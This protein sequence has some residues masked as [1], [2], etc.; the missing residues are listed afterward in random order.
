MELPRSKFAI[1]AIASPLEK[2][3]LE[4]WIAYHKKIG[5]D[6]FFI[7][8]NDWEWECNDSSVVLAKIDGRQ[9][10]CYYYTW[11]ARNMSSYVDWC[12]FI[13]CD[14]FIRLGTKHRTVHDLADENKFKDAICLSWRLF[15]SNGMHF[16]G[17]YNVLSRFTRRQSGFN[18]HIKTVLNLKK[19]ASFGDNRSITFTTPH[20]ATCRSCTGIISYSV[21]NRRIIG[22]YDNYASTELHDNDTWLAHFFCKTPEEWRLKQE[23]GR[24]DVAEDSPLMH[25]PDE[26]FVNHDLNDVEDTSLRDVLC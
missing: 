18:Q 15:G 25:R 20:C 7:A 3:Y 22:P 26:D 13:D 4:E 10:Q 2:N 5:V 8:T 21:D 19:L 14:E 17:D 9:K 1:C 23:R 6:R 11:F 12:A 16:S 24:I